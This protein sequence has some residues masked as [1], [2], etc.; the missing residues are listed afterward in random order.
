MTDLEPV[1][2]KPIVL[3]DVERARMQAAS[4]EMGRRFR[5][6]LEPVMRQLAA[7]VQPVIDAFTALHRALEAAGVYELSAEEIRIGRLEAEAE[8]Y[9]LDYR[10]TPQLGLMRAERGT[11]AHVCGP[12]PDHECQARATD[13]IEHRNLAG[14]TTRMPVCGPCGQSERAAMESEHV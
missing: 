13:V 5:E 8:D 7:M 10:D 4:A 3:S 1:K 11:C 2:P 12:V 6:Q 9:A 14:G